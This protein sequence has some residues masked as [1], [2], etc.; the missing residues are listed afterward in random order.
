MERGEF[1]MHAFR[2]KDAQA[3]GRLASCR[4][5]LRDKSLYSCDSLLKKHSEAMPEWELE[6]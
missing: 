2:P 1:K 3:T 6:R 5:R 4:A